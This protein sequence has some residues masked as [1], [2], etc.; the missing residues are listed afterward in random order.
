MAK[1]VEKSRSQLL[2]EVERKL[3]STLQD[4][5]ELRVMSEKEYL[6]FVDEVLEELAVTNTERLNEIEAEERVAE[7]E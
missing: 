7:E 6:S 4:I 2:T 3:R 1:K 5:P